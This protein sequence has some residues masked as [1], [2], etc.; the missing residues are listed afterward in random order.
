MDQLW[1][2]MKVEDAQL[3]RRSLSPAK[4]ATPAAPTTPAEVDECLPDLVPIGVNAAVAT[5]VSCCSA[6]VEQEFARLQT[7]DREQV[8][9]RTTPD[10]RPPP[11]SEPL[12]GATSPEKSPVRP[13]RP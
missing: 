1:Q 3:G 12:A 10:K 8:T 6:W 13:Q 11:V 5:M 2:Q 7:A 4:R 9:R